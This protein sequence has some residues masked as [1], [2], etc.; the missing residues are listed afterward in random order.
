MQLKY[1]RHIRSSDQHLISKHSKEGEKNVNFIIVA[2]RRNN[3]C[4]LQ[5][6]TKKKRYN[7]ILRRK[8]STI[9]QQKETR[10]RFEIIWRSSRWRFR[11]ILSHFFSRYEG[12]YGR[13]Y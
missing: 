3:R 2:C 9:N 4:M 12:E 5:S 7:R 11:L 13:M 6:E 10:S 1:V 8:P